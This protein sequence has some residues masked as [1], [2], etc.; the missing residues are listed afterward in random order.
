MVNTEPGSRPRLLDYLPA[1]YQRSDEC[2][3][4][5]A[6]FEGTLFGKGSAEWADDGL[7]ATTT[8]LEPLIDGIPA[9]FDPELTLP[10][11]LPWLAQWASVTPHEGIPESRR[12]QL[13]AKLIPLYAIRGTKAYVEKTLWLYLGVKAVVEEE[14]LPGMRVGVQSTVGQDSR[15]GADPFQFH[16]FL[17]LLAGPLDRSELPG[18][19]ELAH[20]VVNLAK[21]AHTRFRLTHNA[22]GREE[23]M[24]ISVHST[25]GID[26]YL[27]HD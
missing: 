14:D 8:G 13:I 5:L 10:E 22:V 15:L 2:G 18:L 27:W 3:R 16:V 23:G 6:A 7:P 11:F 21:P 9:L 25:V 19:L 12:R 1:I 24:V 4:F 26:T 17:D 20:H